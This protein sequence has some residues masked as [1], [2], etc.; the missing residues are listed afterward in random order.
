VN[1][2]HIFRVRGFISI[3]L[4]STSSAKREV[5]IIVFVPQIDSMN[6]EKNKKSSNSHLGMMDIADIFHMKKRK[7]ESKMVKNILFESKF[8]KLKK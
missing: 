4:D 3:N 8:Q 7:N 2:D 6:S 5:P 1:I